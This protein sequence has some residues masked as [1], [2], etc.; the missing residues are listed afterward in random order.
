MFKTSLSFF[1]IIR[2]DMLRA[3]GRYICCGR[4][5]QYRGPWFYADLWFC[6]SSLWWHSQ[7]RQERSQSGVP[8]VCFHSLRKPAD[9]PNQLLPSNICTKTE[10]LHTGKSVT[11]TVLLWCQWLRILKGIANTPVNNNV[12][13]A[14]EE[15]RPFILHFYGIFWFLHM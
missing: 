3:C 10:D 1:S 8:H 2:P 7:R 11:D 12:F 15:P 6:G 4:V 13:I 9:F 14:V 5:L